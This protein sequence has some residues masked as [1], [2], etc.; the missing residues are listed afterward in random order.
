MTPHEVV[1]ID[2]DVP[3]VSQVTYVVEEI[4]EYEVIYVQKDHQQFSEHD[5]YI[6]KGFL[7]S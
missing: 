7:K 6:R 1:E 5:Q 3:K 4:I 2:Q